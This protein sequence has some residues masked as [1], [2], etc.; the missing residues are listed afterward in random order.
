[1]QPLKP[2]TPPTLH[3]AV[4]LTEYTHPGFAP[5]PPAL[6]LHPPPV[7]LTDPNSLASLAR[8]LESNPNLLLQVASS[9]GQGHLQAQPSSHPDQMTSNPLAAML[10]SVAHLQATGATALNVSV[11]VADPNNLVQAL[12]ATPSLFD[13]VKLAAALASLNQPSNIDGLHNLDQGPSREKSAELLPPQLSPAPS[14]SSHDAWDSNVADYEEY[15]LSLGIELTTS[16]INRAD[17][18]ALADVLYGRIPQYCRQDGA[19]F[20]NGRIGDARASAQLDAHFRIQRRAREQ[21]NRAQQRLWAV[22]EADWV[23]SH[24]FGTEHETQKPKKVEAAMPKSASGGLLKTTADLKQKMVLRPRDPVEASRPCPICREGFETKFDEDEEEYYWL[25]AIGMDR[26]VGG[27]TERS[28]VFYHATCHFET[29]R[30]KARMKLRREEEEANLRRKK[31]EQEQKDEEE[32]KKEQEQ[33]EQSVKVKVEGEEEVAF[34]PEE[35][36]ADADEDIGQA[37]VLQ[38]D[39]DF[40]STVQSVVDVDGQESSDEGVGQSNPG[41]LSL[42]P[43]T[44][45]LSVK[46]RKSLDAEDGSTDDDDEVVVMVGGGDGS[47]KKRAKVID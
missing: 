24:D 36:G 27:T 23:K 17:P 13:S 35:K 25:N 9:Q 12:A 22:L 15:V 4:D 44:Q 47:S 3:P 8:L 29:M 40:F 43:K 21:T 19:R 26:K 39:D 30:N 7:D 33:R 34:L 32:Q 14:T 45:S 18:A 46:K 5:L 20:L 38:L 37:S 16:S 41:N 1:M 11:P 28:E 31:E 6:E 10:D 42:E 2:A